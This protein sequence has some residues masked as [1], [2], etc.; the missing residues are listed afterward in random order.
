MS[1]PDD[2]L[3]HLILRLPANHPQLLAGLEDWLQRGLISEAQI[4]PWCEVNL[5][6]RIP[7][8]QGLVSATPL[9]STPPVLTP[10]LIAS[11][12]P[13]PTAATI[14]SAGN[15]LD[16]W[17]SAEPLTTSQKP[18]QPARGVSRLIQGLAEEISLRWLLFL[19]VFLVIVS[20]GVLAASQWNRFSP[21]AQYWVL[22]AYT[23]AFF[24]AGQV[25]QRRSNL[26]LTTQTLHCVSLLLVP[27]NFW[28]MDGLGLWHS[29]LGWLTLVLAVPLLL[30]FS[31]R[32]AQTDRSLWGFGAL[33]L[34]QWGWRIPLWPLIAVYGGVFAT[35]L[36]SRFWGKGRTPTDPLTPNHSTTQPLPTPLL[37]TPTTPPHSLSFFGQWTIWYGLAILVLRAIFVAGVDL[38]QLGLA[39]GLAG[40]FV[41]RPTQVRGSVDLTTPELAT[42]DLT[43]ANLT[44]ETLTT[45]AATAAATAGQTSA[46]TQP[47]PR[48]AELLG[49]A[50]LLVGWAVTLRTLPLQTIAISGLGLAFWG[51]RLS[52]Q[53]RRQDWLTVVTIALQLGYQ[54][55][56]IIPP[57]IQEAIV[58]WG[59]RLTQTQDT[60]VSLLSLVGFV[61][62]FGLVIAAQWFQV[63]R[64]YDLVKLT[65][66]LTVLLTSVLLT[67]SLVTAPLRTLC[68]GLGTIASGLT[69]FRPLPESSGI[70]GAGSVY[71]THGLALATLLLGMAWVNPDWEF[72]GWGWF[73]LGLAVL[74]WGVGL[75]TPAQGSRL[76][77]GQ[78][79]GLLWAIVFSLGSYGFFFFSLSILNP[80]PLHTLVWSV[81]PLLLTGLG[82][83]HRRKLSL[84]SRFGG[85]RALESQVLGSR[86]LKGAVVAVCL[87]Q[88]LTLWFPV[89][90]QWGLLYG[91]MNLLVISS[92]A[93]R[94]ILAGLTLGFAF[95]S[96]L[97]AL[98][99]YLQGFQ[100]L[101][102]WSVALNLLWGVDRG[103]DRFLTYK[104]THKTEALPPS[105]RPNSRP[106]S[107]SK[108]L[109]IIQIYHFALQGWSSTIALGLGVFFTLTALIL[110]VFYRDL[111]I[112]PL[113]L[114]AAVILFGVALIH[115]SYPW[116]TNAHFY[117]LAWGLELWLIHG[118]SYTQVLLFGSRFPAY[119]LPWAHLGLGL[120]SQLLGHWL[121]R[122]D[123]QRRSLVCFQII[124]LLWAGLAGLSRWNLFTPWT[125]VITL[126][127]AWIA[128]QV[129]RSKPEPDQPSGWKGW[130][131]VALGGLTLGMAELIAYPLRDNLELIPLTW[132][133]LGGA[134][135]IVYRY[136]TPQ[137]LSA[138]LH[139]PIRHLR[140]LGHLHWGLS[141]GLMGLL[142]LAHLDIPNGLPEL[143]FSTGILL[144][145]YALAQARQTLSE[146][147][148]VVWTYGSYLHLSGLFLYGWTIAPELW[149]EGFKAWGL[150]IVAPLGVLS[151][152]LPWQRWGWVASPWQQV[153]VRVPLLLA[154]VTLSTATSGSWLVVSL[155]YGALS[156]ATGKL[157]L[158]YLALL[159]L[160]ATVWR[161]CIEND[162]SGM[163]WYSFPLAASL[164]W[165][166]AIDPH[167]KETE[168]RETRH[169]LRLF[170][171]ALICGVPL[172]PDQ[173]SPLVIIGLS[174]L[175]ILAGLTLRTRAFL[176]G[177]T[178]IFLGYSFY[179]LVILV[180]QQSLL[181]WAIGLGLG[182]LMIWTAATFETRRDQ[183]RSILYNWAD[184]L[185]D[186]A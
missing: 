2:R 82:Y 86:F 88:G 13:I 59:T 89:T 64:H 105:S 71:L 174:L 185:A 45:T 131:Y 134:L 112:I 65:D 67:L 117:T 154:I 19:G 104:L 149:Q 126:G 109:K 61:Y 143:T 113:T 24:G 34:L 139:I 167:L 122:R 129:G 77:H 31:Q 170:A 168:Q 107:E 115:R 62:V 130:S 119:V 96:S 79:S 37:P 171:T 41:T 164:L 101:I 38:P 178:A 68:F 25:C 103:I 177:G 32:L 98:N 136:L 75:A 29:A 14:G 95:L 140:Q 72:L 110:S 142:F 28:A 169:N 180:T 163:L 123:A 124:P 43:T 12:P 63:R 172:F 50:L 90:R 66:I 47:V 137:A 73:T 162:R 102:Y 181:K 55:W 8:A 17:E 26:Q 173:G 91:L 151:Y 1:L 57:T 35:Q 100:W 99:P 116:R 51:Q 152:L 53:W 22:L 30:V 69:L 40:W 120:T 84:G 44:T 186:W 74:H 33:S 111:T 92:L 106:N 114:L 155:S 60:P 176:Y 165:V 36:S 179:Q 4:R 148:A 11:P 144:T 156:Y 97:L 133:G 157:R 182:I 118:L 141:T 80:A 87:L 127:M 160:D 175:S 16:Q 56:R 128:L 184:A 39:I 159:F 146:D 145:L 15:P 3:L 21:W 81:I 94:V 46:T 121:I 5:S 158:S 78:R 10:S 125:G 166:T 7:D 108:F 132:A 83:W 23:T 93:P 52:Q 9:T 27:V 18:P 150:A 20:S 76:W 70:R 147:N 58:T 135:A 6:S 138:Y 54:I 42:P 49:M 183:I 85:E 48:I 161:W 153:G